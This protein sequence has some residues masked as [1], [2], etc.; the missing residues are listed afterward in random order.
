MKASES[1]YH[2]K[3]TSLLRN[4]SFFSTLQ[5]RNSL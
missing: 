3:D 1:K 4:V 2:N 5:I